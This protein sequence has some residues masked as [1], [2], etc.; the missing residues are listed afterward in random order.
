VVA[1]IFT[2]E[3]MARMADSDPVEATERLLKLA[4][5]AEADGTF[6]FS[7]TIWVATA[8]KP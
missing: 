2:R 6:L 5:R 8:T 7:L 1:P 3:A 4:E